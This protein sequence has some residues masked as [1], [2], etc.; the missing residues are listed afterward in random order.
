MTVCIKINQ[1]HIFNQMRQTTRFSAMKMN[2]LRMF[3]LFFCRIDQK[4]ESR[5]LVLAKW[6]NISVDKVSSFNKMLIKISS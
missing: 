1:Q 3:S 6:F 4:E 2:E 5:L